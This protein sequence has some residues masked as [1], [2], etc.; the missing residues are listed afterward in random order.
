MLYRI[1]ILLLFSQYFVTNTS[2]NL[3]RHVRTIYGDEDSPSQTKNTFVVD[4][5]VGNEV[6]SATHRQKRAAGPTTDGITTKVI[7]CNIFF[8]IRVYYFV[9]FHWYNQEVSN[10]RV[11][12]TGCDGEE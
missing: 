6:S 4:A 12:V 9:T 2:A 8:V 10:K 5:D 3:E 1:L 7:Y 11:T